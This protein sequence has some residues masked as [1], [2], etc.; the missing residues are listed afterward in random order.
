VKEFGFLELEVERL[1]ES[2]FGSPTIRLKPLR[3]FR[4]ALMV[5]GG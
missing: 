1:E 2:L 3:G 5:L 4:F